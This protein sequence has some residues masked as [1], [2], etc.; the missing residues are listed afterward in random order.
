LKQFLPRK[1]LFSDSKEI[2]K[3]AVFAQPFTLLELARRET[4]RTMLRK[5][6]ERTDENEYGFGWHC[7]SD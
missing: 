6:Y 4:D 7:G 3:P 2:T 5:T 1:S